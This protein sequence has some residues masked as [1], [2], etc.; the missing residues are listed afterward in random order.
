MFFA[1]YCKSIRRFMGKIFSIVTNRGSVSLRKR[2]GGGRSFQGW[3][4]ERALIKKKRKFSSCK[5]IL[6]GLSAKSFMRKGFL[7]FDEMRIYFVVYE[8]AVCQI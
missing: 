2:E 1:P 8:E 5:G 4:N 6:K 3:G 7:I